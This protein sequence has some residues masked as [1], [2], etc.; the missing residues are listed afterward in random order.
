MRFYFRKRPGPRYPLPSDPASDDFVEAYSAALSGSVKAKRLRREAE[1]PRSIAALVRSYLSSTRYTN[2]RATTKKSYKSRLEAI[3]IGHGHRAVAGLTMDRIEK[4]LL[5]PYANKPGAKL[6]TL[7]MLRVLIRQAIKLQWITQDP[8]IG[9]DR[10]KGGEIRSWTDSEILQFQKRWPVSTKQRTAFALHLYTGQRRSDVHRMTWAD[11]LDGAIKV[12]QQK[13][14]AKLTIS[15]H[16]ELRAAL[17]HADRGHITILN[18]AY[19]KPFTISGYGQ[20][21]RDAITAAELPLDC[22]PHGLR[23]A[24]GR[25]LADAGC[26]AH[27][28]MSVLGHKSLSEAERYTREANQENLNKSAVLKLERHDANK[29]AQTGSDKFGK[30]AKT[31]GKSK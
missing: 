22:K 12:V 3:R 15:L 1:K 10:P 18:T 26:T 30:A 9:I 13:T 25:R 2:L 23:K 4:A 27:E 11:V 5:Q 20:W 7:K 14:G 24:A 28:I 21:L 19:G 8:S 31:K 17:A 6:A 16:H 29:P